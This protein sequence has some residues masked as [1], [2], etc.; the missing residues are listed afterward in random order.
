MRRNLSVDW[1]A[2]GHYATDLFTEHAIETIAKHN[3][4]QPMFMILAHNAPHAG[5]EYA[6][7]QAP[8]DEINKFKYIRNKNRRTYAA[9]VSK[10]DESV[11]KVIESLERNDMLENSII[12]LMSDNGAPLEGMYNNSGSNFPLKGVCTANFFQHSVVFSTE[13][14]IIFQSKCI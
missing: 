4:S 8:E 9:M 11:G 3:K 14:L 7:L 10:L 5:N 2:I 1:S 13:R 6:L 12:L